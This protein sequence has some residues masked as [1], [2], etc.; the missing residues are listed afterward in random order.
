[1]RGKSNERR[2]AKADGV[3]TVCIAGMH[4]SGTSL[5]AN[6]F[7]HCG[8]PM[9]DDLVGPGVGNRLGH[10]EDRDFLEFHKQLLVDNRTNMFVPRKPVFVSQ[11]RRVEARALLARKS[12]QH[13]VWGWKEPRTS[14]FLDLWADLHNGLRF[15]FMYREPLV[16]V[17][18][19]YRQMKIK[20][21]YGA[22]W[23]A[24]QSWIHY[25][26][27]LLDFHA[28]QPRRCV[29]VNINGFNAQ[30]RANA[31]RLADA[32][33]VLLDRPYEDVYRHQEMSSGQKP[34]KPF[35]IG[36]YLGFAQR[37]WGSR[38]DALMARIDDVALV[39]SPSGQ[40]N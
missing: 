37:W 28:R 33:G 1:M 12:S 39:R 3:R 7:Q 8:I 32:I 13:P 15:V 24:V 34:L 22:P 5:M 40:S 20:Y 26:E 4:R 23:L 27:Q 10:F 35:P 14:L 6:Y 11:Q 36:L 19:L 30:P 31:Q 18:S 38:L 16:V 9:G 17:E 29:F 21:L 2:S 25:N